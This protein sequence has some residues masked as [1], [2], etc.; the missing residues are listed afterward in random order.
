M[1]SLI[2]H[3][4][5]L[6]LV[7]SDLYQQTYAK[8]KTQLLSSRQYALLGMAAPL[9]FV[10]TFG[11]MGFLR[12]EDAELNQ[13]MHEFGSLTHGNNWI[14]NLFGYALVGAL[15]A[16]FSIGLHRA[17]RP[18]GNRD[19][20]FWSLLLSGILFGLSGMISGEFQF[21]PQAMISLHRIGKLGSM[22]GF[23][24]AIFAYRNWF[25]RS[26]YWKQAVFPSLVFAGCYIL[27][28]LSRD[29]L[30]PGLGERIQLIFYFVWIGYMA[31]LLFRAPIEQDAQHFVGFP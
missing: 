15:I 23:L 20:A 17:I 27:G 26:P 14:W 3:A 10:L 29:L 18:T 9:L 24:L 16:G 13:S 30:L 1:A 28:G 2:V 6:L 7:F 19:V 21:S 4:V 25:V 8:M 12:P 5:F 31:I 11:L 22:I